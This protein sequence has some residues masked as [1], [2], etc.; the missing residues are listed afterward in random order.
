M[1]AAG[2]AG[3]AMGV[4]LVWAVSVHVALRHGIRSGRAAERARL[5]RTLHDTVLPALEAF[6]V[7]SPTDEAAPGAALAE[8]RGAARAQAGRLRRTL[9]EANGTPAS[10]LAGALTD[11]TG[12]LAVRGLRVEL[13]VAAGAGQRLRYPYR[14]AVLGA[15]REA[16]GNVVKHAGVGDAVV[17]VAEDRGRLVV[18]IRDHGR[19]F[20]ATNGHGG[21][22]IRQSIVAR[23]R[24]VGGEATVESWPGRGTR[25]TLRAP[26]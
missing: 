15:T 2:V 21:F 17:R 3:V 6:A 18:V 11:L 5:L 16:L 24:D 25:V 26:A 4:L 14:E 22:G 23:L 19:G 10:S 9:T 8:L 7:T 12:E 13:A 20:D 1:T